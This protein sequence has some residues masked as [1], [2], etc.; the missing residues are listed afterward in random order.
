MAEVVEEFKRILLAKK[1]AGKNT[2]VISEVNRKILSDINSGN[3]VFPAKTAEQQNQQ[4]SS[5][6]NL[7]SFGQAS[8]SSPSFMTV[9]N[10]PSV[11]TAPPVSSATVET[12]PPLPELDNLSWFELEAAMLHCRSCELCTSRQNVVCGN[13]HHNARLMFIGEAPGVEEDQQGMAFVGK[14]G[15]MLTNMIKAMGFERDSEDPNKAVFIADIVK[16]RPPDNRNP[17]AEEAQICLPFLKK[18]IDLL[19]PQVIV[20]LGGIAL[21]FLFDIKGINQHRG[22]WL[23]YQ[24]I[25]VM[26][27]FHP[28]YLLRFEHQKT[29]FVEEKRKV[30]SDLQQ[31]MAKLQGIRE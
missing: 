24:G 2:A 31:V 23:D 21:Q 17:K 19:K 18:Q 22:V 8:S 12:Y 13:G 16:C 9:D 15:Q 27:T 11:E 29:F 5:A 14:A 10:I 4:P 28:D 7:T 3:F 26:P 1:A 20:L 30:W 25:P 6:T